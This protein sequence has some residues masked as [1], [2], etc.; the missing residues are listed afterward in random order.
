[1]DKKGRTTLASIKINDEIC[2]GDYGI[3]VSHDPLKYHTEHIDFT[4]RVPWNENITVSIML[5][6]K[7]DKFYHYSVNVNSEHHTFTTFQMIDS[8]H[9]RVSQGTAL[10]EDINY[11][12][13]TAE[14][15]Q[16]EQS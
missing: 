8:I 16:G 3:V 10:I 13:R 5:N 1:M 14:P 12:S 9:F 4:T 15:K 6:H 2:R 11:S 7:V